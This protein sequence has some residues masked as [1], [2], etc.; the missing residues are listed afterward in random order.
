MISRT[1]SSLVNCSH[2]A[3]L[4]DAAYSKVTLGILVATTTRC[5]SS[6]CQ[7]ISQGRLLSHT[8][9]ETVASPTAS[10]LKITVARQ[11]RISSVLQ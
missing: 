2:S 9:D 10:A 6:A 4:R 5:F 7:N 11:L 3:R 8:V 1:C